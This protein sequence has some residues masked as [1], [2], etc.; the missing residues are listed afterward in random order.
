MKATYINAQEFT[1]ANGVKHY[2]I[3]YAATPD[4]PVTRFNDEHGT[5][6]QVRLLG[7]K[8]FD[9]KCNAE[10][11]AALRSTDAGSDVNFQLEPNPSNPRQNIITG[12]VA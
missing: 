12:I 5:E 6:L 2:K 1:D 8:I 10:A 3:R 4:Q 11:F 9:I 7:K